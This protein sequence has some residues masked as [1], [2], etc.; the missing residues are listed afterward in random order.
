MAA[1]VTFHT[2]PFDSGVCH[3]AIF[4]DTAGNPLSLHHR[5]AEPN[6]AGDQSTLVP[7]EICRFG[8]NP[9]QGCPADA[10][11]QPIRADTH[12]LPFFAYIID[13]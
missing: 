8:P 2:E 5:Y 11:E 3:Q 10:S 1:G 4:R 13:R 9:R 6:P 12:G 7:R